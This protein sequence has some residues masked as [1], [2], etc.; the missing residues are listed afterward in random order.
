MVKTST[1]AD[2]LLQTNKPAVKRS[3]VGMMK[4]NCLLV[5]RGLGMGISMRMDITV[6]L[7]G[8]L[9]QSWVVRG[10]RGILGIGNTLILFAS[11]IL[12]K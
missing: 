2:V 8:G 7:F 11:M 6:S 5:D 4:R 1:L 12:G 9:R 10:V 3:R